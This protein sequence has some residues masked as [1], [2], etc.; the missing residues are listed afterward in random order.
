MGSQRSL[1][2]VLIGLALLG[3]LLLGLA[4]SALSLTWLA[5][6]AC[7]GAILAAV[8]LCARWIIGPSRARARRRAEKARASL[9]GQY[10]AGK[11]DRDTYLRLVAERRARD[12]TPD[13]PATQPPG[14]TAAP[15]PSSHGG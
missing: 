15:T 11:L 14:D 9:K 12:A 6:V 1:K 8:A 5:V 7:S 2:L 13:S 3:L 10:K 4:G